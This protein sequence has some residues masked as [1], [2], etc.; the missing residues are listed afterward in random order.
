MMSMMAMEI[1]LCDLDIMARELICETKKICVDA[2][3][4]ANEELP[5]ESMMEIRR[6]LADIRTT[7]QICVVAVQSSILPILLKKYCR[8]GSIF[9]KVQT[10]L[11]R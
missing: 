7:R 6:L 1:D 4:L 11:S 3:K 5:N 10:S 8:C 9:L 2:S